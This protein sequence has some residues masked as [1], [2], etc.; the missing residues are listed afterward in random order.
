MLR[1]SDRICEDGEVYRHVDFDD[2]DGK[3]ME[4]VLMLLK[5]ES[6]D[7]ALPKFVF[8]TSYGEL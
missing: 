4:E 3:N 7:F 2:F 6:S 8:E 1:E 5:T